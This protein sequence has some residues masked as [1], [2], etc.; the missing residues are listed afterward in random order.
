[1]NSVFHGRRFIFP[2]SIRSLEIVSVITIFE[3]EGLVKFY[4]YE[5]GS[6][7]WIFAQKVITLCVIEYVINP[8]GTVE[9]NR[10]INAEMMIGGD[11]LS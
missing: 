3:P 9:L 10:I 2:C 5:A 6:S 8:V 1:M 7:V 11:G 4:P